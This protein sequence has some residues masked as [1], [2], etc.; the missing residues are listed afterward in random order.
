MRVQESGENDVSWFWQVAK[1]WNSPLP[2]S[3]EQVPES[4]TLVSPTVRPAAVTSLMST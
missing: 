2:R 1:P 3:L 4:V